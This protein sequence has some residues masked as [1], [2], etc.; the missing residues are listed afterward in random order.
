[1]AATRSPESAQPTLERPEPRARS[2]LRAAAAIVDVGLVAVPLIGV[3]YF[4]RAIADGSG[5]GQADRAVF[6]ALGLATAVALY[7]WNSGLREGRTGASLGKQ[8][9]GLITRDAT[10]GGPIGPRRALAP[11]RT[12]RRGR[13]GEIRARS[14]LRPTRPGHLAG[15][16]PASTPAG[17]CRVGD[18][19]GGCGAGEPR[20]RRAGDEPCRIV[21]ALVHPTGTETDKVVRTLRVP[22]TALGLVVGI[23]L[24]IAGALIQGTPA[25]RSP[26][27]A[28]SASTPAPRSSS[29]CRSTCSGSAR[30]ASTCGSRSPGRSR[31]SVVVFGIVIDRR[32]AGEP[33]QPGPGRRGGRVLPRR[34]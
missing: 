24:G 30:R 28:C 20:G 8:W 21:H 4:L 10:T 1:M 22:R 3:W 9:A 23:A 34:R 26:T 11:I 17:C 19:G 18:T 25:T 6:G 31:P 33:A 29:C 32:R 5:D 14:R 12:R 27:R 16:G 2:P 13:G 7:V 15:G